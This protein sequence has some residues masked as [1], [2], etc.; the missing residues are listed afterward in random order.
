MTSDK[1]LKDVEDEYIYINAVLQQEKNIEPIFV[2]SSNLSFLKG[3][4]EKFKNHYDLVNIYHYVDEAIYKEFRS[5]SIPRVLSGYGGDFIVSAPMFP[6]PHLLRDGRFAAFFKL[7]NKIRSSENLTYFS[8]FRK[9]I[10]SPIIPFD[11]RNLW[12]RLKGRISFWNID[13]LPLVLNVQEKVKL[14]S[15]IKALAKE[16]Q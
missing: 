16:R 8:L 5:R 15:K 11:V 6:L 14:Q 10:L 9:H 2:Y 7:A 3:L 4:N 1:N 13:N 12:D